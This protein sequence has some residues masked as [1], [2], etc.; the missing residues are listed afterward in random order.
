LAR[1]KQRPRKDRGQAKKP[2]AAVLTGL[3]VIGG[4]QSLLARE[5]KRPLE[6]LDTFR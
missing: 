3:E 5:E 4:G 6:P 2:L 1:R